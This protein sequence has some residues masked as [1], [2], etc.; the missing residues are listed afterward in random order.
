MLNMRGATH[1]D[2]EHG[3]SPRE[4]ARIRAVYDQRERTVPGT[5]K[6]DIANRGTW[7]LL[8]EHRSRLG[9]IL[10][11]NFGRS[12]TDCRVL[13]VGC[14]YG[15]LLA[16]FHE[17]GVPAQNLFGVDLLPNR[18]AA[19]RSAYPRFTF[20]EGNAERFDLPDGS[21]DLIPVFTVFSSILDP[22]M[23]ANVAHEISR[24][25]APGGAVVWYDMRYPNPWN[26][27]LKAMT[28]RRTRHLFPAFSCELETISLL[29][30]LARRLGP[31][32]DRAYPMLAAIPPLRSH[33]LGLLRPLPS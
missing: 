11:D 26:P 27:D 13:D 5:N 12:L 32:T 20:A 24:V 19:A 30:Q 7:H 6:V 9:H 21:F 15:S 28:R 31:L 16:W 17:L 22:G 23:A 25:L 4:I 3:I 1:Q 29:P 2:R 14:G 33:L 8:H 18:I 10:R